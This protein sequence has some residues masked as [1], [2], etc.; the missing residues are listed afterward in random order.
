MK[1]V[2]FADLVHMQAKK[3]GEKAALYYKDE[4]LN[5][6]VSISWNSLSEQ[7]KTI[8]KALFEIGVG[9]YEN[10]GIFSQNKPEGII[11]DYAAFANRAV[12]V[13]MYATSSSQQINYIINDAEIAVLFVGEQVQYDVACEVLKKSKYLKKIV[14]FDENVKTNG[15]ENVMYFSDLMTIGQKS[16][17]HFEVNARQTHASEDDLATIMYTSGTTGDP[18]GAMI[19]HSCYQ[20]AMRIHDIRITSVSDKDSSLA[21][22]P[23]SHIFERAWTYF[24]L[25]KAIEVYVNLRPQEIQQS[26]KEVRPTLMCS[27]PRFWEKVYDGVKENI[28]N[29]SPLKQ[30]IVTWAI[31][32]G[33]KYNLDYLRLG[34]TPHLSL[35]LRYLIADKLI[36]SKVKKTIG[37][38]NGNM[39]LTAGAKLSDEINEFFRSIGIPIIYGY[40]LTETTATVTCF[41]YTHYN[42]GTVGEIMPDIDVKIGEDNEI[43]V[44]AKTVFKGYYKKPEATA[45]A[46]TADGWFRTGDAGKIHDNQI[47]L[48]ERIKDLFKTSNG[49]YIAPQQIESVIAVDKY[50]D[51]VAVVGDERNYVTAIIVP[52]IEKLKEYADKEKIKYTD[53]DE[54]LSL[55]SI[56]SFYKERIDNLQKGLAEFEKIKR[57]SFI[58]KGF[59]LE[60]GE[61]TN[62]LKLRRV[63]ILQKYKDLIDEMYTRKED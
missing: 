6:W 15:E 59:T 9:E 40:G 63:V 37:I 35:K 30:G 46:F 21:F 16:T 32:V 12:T 49:K 22:L 56:K 24:C 18:K 52:A 41:N 47:V 7:V 62:T 13:P 50:I 55:S 45:A 43:L 48:T 19:P 36:F 20:E 3:Y 42:I 51:Q 29:F 4:K 38:E 33:K 58:K 39:F 54:L 1:N 14:I 10:L 11:V 27:V 60:A 17:A 34:K 53:I 44:K 28:A 26:V 61:M 8:A 57:F 5:R 25:Y 2:H 23:L 31:A